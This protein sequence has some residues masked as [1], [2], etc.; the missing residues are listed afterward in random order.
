MP[1]KGLLSVNVHRK[2]C[3]VIVIHTLMII[4]YL[5]VLS[6]GVRQFCVCLFTFVFFL[7]M[8]PC[9][10]PG[11][12]FRK[13][14]KPLS[15]GLVVKRPVSVLHFIISNILSW[16]LIVNL[17]PSHGPVARV[18]LLVDCYPRWI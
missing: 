8:L 18:C 7:V 5:R 6:V 10:S 11:T 13:R 15:R 17:L 3:Y 14:I 4:S 2:V 9:V 12:D 1:G 16:T